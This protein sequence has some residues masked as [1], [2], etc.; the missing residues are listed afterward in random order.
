MGANVSVS[1]I[2][3]EGS[4]KLRKRPLIRFLY[5]AQ[6]RER[7]A[8]YMILDDN[9]PFISIHTIPPATPGQATIISR[10]VTEKKTS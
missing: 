3:E 6:R 7:R 10:Q 4:F 5:N 1:Q 8:G 9:S 2:R